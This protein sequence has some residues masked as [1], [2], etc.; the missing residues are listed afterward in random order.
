MR[1][2]VTVISNAATSALSADASA[3]F[4]LDEDEPEDERVDE[5]A[6]DHSD[7]ERAGESFRFTASLR[8]LDGRPES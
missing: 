5:H 8:G 7:E 4:G 2:F 1:A 6:A 3:R